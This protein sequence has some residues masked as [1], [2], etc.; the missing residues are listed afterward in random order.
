MADAYRQPNIVTER[1]VSGRPVG[2]R[3]HIAIA[4]AIMSQT[5]PR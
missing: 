1:L 3:R 2:P 5:A 4:S